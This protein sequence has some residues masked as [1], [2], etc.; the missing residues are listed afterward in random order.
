MLVLA[1]SVPFLIPVESTGT[2]DY[3]EAAP[4]RGE[5]VEVA[6]TDV[7][8]EQT[9]MVCAAGGDCPSDTL[10]IL[11]HGFGASSFSFRDIRQQLAAF[12]DVLSYDRPGFGFTERPTSWS[13][14]N[15]YG[16][17]GN[18]AILQALIERFGQ[19]K[20]IVL[21]GHSAG[22]TL[23][24]QFALDYPGKV[25]S[26]IL[27][28]PAIYSSGGMPAFLNWLLFIPQLDR[29]GPLLVSSISSS[30]MELLKRSWYDQGKLTQD[31][32]DGYRAPLEIEGWERG[33]W[34]FTRA[35]R[36]FDVADR[37]GELKLPVLVITGDSDQVVPSADSERAAGAIENS[38]LFV[39]PKTGHLPQEETSEQTL[40]SIKVTWSILS[41]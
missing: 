41:R 15:P 11:L 32:I 25:Q 22:G 5:F 23:A 30:G 17:K 18:L 40:K 24:T 14:E 35:D 38:V 8:L 33:F 13:G 12:G 16:K 6:G 10:I 7:Y 28:A 36:D 34:E 29:L 20:K 21:V 37:L 9:P 39:L 31:I 27:I 26:L 1:L 4:A 2:K 19:S 3:R